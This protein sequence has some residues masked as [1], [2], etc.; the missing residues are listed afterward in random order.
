AGPF[1]ILLGLLIFVHE[2]GHFLVAKYFGV[3]VEVFSLGF[4][5]KI[6]KYKKGDT[7]YC[8]SIIPLGGYVKMYGD[9]PT[10]E[11]PEEEKKYSFLHQPVWPRIAIVLAGPLMNLFFAFILFASVA[12]LG[13]KKPAPVIG[14]VPP[15][16]QAFQAGFRPGDTILQINDI[17]VKT[18]MD[19]EKFIQSHA[20]QKLTFLVQ[21]EDRQ[22]TLTATPRWNQTFSPLHLD[23]KVGQIQGLSFLSKAPFVGVSNPQ[24][25][26]AQFGFPT[27]SSI[28]S[29]NNKKIL[30]FRDIHPSLETASFPL[31]FKIKKVQLENPNTPI[32]SV[33][34]PQL[35]K[36][37][38][39]NLFDQLGLE[40]SDLFILRPKKGSPAEK[41]GLQAGDKI[42]SINNKKMSRWQEISETVRHY[43]EGQ[44]PLTFTVIRDGKIKNLKVTP[45]LSEVNKMNG[46]FEKRYL[47]GILPAISQ[48]P[49][50]MVLVRETNP[51][52]A[53]GQGFM[54]SAQWT[55][56]IA[57]SFYKL[58]TNQ[59]S[60]K[61]LGGIISIGR[62]AGE[63]FAIGLS[64]F[65]KMMAIISINLF[66][67]NLL[68]IPVLDGGHLLFF[69][70]E[71]FRG[72]PVS[73][74][75]MEIAQQIGLFILLFLM[76]FSIFNDITNHFLSRW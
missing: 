3:R 22:L 76:V 36:D 47:V 42:V 64:P 43:K 56:S 1:I 73:L 59:V 57:I 67:L 50:P 15:Q 12:F 63:S 34:I 53:L 8:I 7:V 11:I 29:I 6:L 71:A 52:K 65:L 49:G 23:S 26:A 17:K 62:V 37:P 54:A 24:S 31:S 55:G 30:Y 58:I 72:T 28:L 32:K 9:D 27:L 4:G 61:N 39:K 69:S 46:Q 19:V 33:T 45:K 75:K 5:K 48:V 68:P 51:L 35:Q 66:L 25:P 16:S 13:E 74:R 10:T 60:A 14:D 70:I 18:W 2:L 40:P 38:N 44:P 21:R 20:S 41:A